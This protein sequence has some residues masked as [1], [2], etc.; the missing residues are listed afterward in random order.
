MDPNQS[1]NSLASVVLSDVSENQALADKIICT[2]LKNETVP[3]SKEVRTVLFKSPSIMDLVKCGVELVKNEDL[4]MGKE[5]LI[6][7][8]RILAMENAGNEQSDL[9]GAMIEHGVVKDIIDMMLPSA[10]PVIATDSEEVPASCWKCW[11]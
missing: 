11:T 7:A 6:A 5:R 3:G 10:V 2:F 4:L 8:L 9:L 1:C